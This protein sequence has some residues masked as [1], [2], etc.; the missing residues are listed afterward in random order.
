VIR[1]TAGI[2]PDEA[3]RWRENGCS[4]VLPKALGPREVARRLA[5]FVAPRADGEAAVG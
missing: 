2:D 4:F 3:R 1:L 5:A